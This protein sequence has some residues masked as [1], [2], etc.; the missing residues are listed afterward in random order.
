MLDCLQSSKIGIVDDIWFVGYDV[1][2]R[3]HNKTLRE[4][5]QICQ[6]ENLK[7]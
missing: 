5:M 6:P 7:T 4:V 2:G 3:D 1:D